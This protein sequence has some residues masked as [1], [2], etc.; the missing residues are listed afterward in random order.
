MSFR[1]GKNI[2][3]VAVVLVIVQIAGFFFP[4]TL[5]FTSVVL[6]GTALL[7]VWDYVALRKQVV[8]LA[9]TRVVPVRAAR[10]RRF[11]VRI[12]IQNSGQQ[13]LGIIRDIIPDGVVPAL[14][15]SRILLRPGATEVEHVVKAD[16]RGLYQFGEIWLRIPG[17]LGMLEVSKAYAS[18]S[19]VRIMPESLFPRDEL[20]KEALDEQR[21]LDQISRTQIRGEGTEFESLSEFREGDDVRRIDWRSTARSGHPILRRY[22]VEQHRDVV[23]LLD[24][25]RL[26]GTAVGDGSKLD[27]AVNA[28]LVIARAALQEGD[29]CGLG[30]FDSQVRGYLAPV[31][32]V[33]SHKAIVER[34]Y[35]LQPSWHETNFAPMFAM[36]QARLQK[37]ALIVIFSDIMESETTERYRAALAALQSRH[38]VLFAALQTPLLSSVAFAPVVNEHDVVRSAFSLRLM[39]E[40]QQTLH[41]LK[42]LGIQIVDAD[43]RQVT[44]PLVN[45]YLQAKERSV[46]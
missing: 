15:Q 16:R 30:I 12:F 5:A 32:G 1:P 31:A 35:D 20:H 28:A 4:W 21:L 13:C 18:D 45:L 26:M 23:L 25:G 9:I 41:G 19:Q 36:L 10:S 7:A 8:A 29:R 24:T 40:R 11:P 3:I 33:C 14:Y 2:I 17:P 27:C 34:L 37:R 6:V 42:R 39:R 43:P 46:A 38:V 44:V 22:Q